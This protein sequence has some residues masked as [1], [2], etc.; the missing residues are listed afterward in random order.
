VRE[1]NDW[2]EVTGCD[3]PGVG[4]LANPAKRAVRTGLYATV[5]ECQATVIRAM[6]V[7]NIPSLLSRVA[8]RFTTGGKTRAGVCRYS[9][10]MRSCEIML[11][12]T[13]WGA[14]TEEQRFNVLMHEAA[15]AV[16]FL[17]HG[18]SSHDARWQAIA[19]QLGCTGDRCLS[20]EETDV[21]RGA[22]AE[23]KGLPAP[24]PIAD[25][26]A[27]SEAAKASLKV[28]DNVSFEHKGQRLYGRLTARNDKSATVFMAPGAMGERGGSAR[29]PWH[30]LQK[31]APSVHKEK[32]EGVDKP[33]A[34]ESLS[35]WQE[36]TGRL[37]ANPAARKKWLGGTTAAF[38]R[39][40][41]DSVVV[42]EDGQPKACYHGTK[43]GGFQAFSKGKIDKHHAGFFFSDNADV[44][45][46][47]TSSSN[48]P[49]YGKQ[50]LPFQ[51]PKTI[52]E[53]E[54][55]LRQHVIEKRFFSSA[56][57]QK[58][59]L[60]LAKSQSFSTV[61]Y[62]AGEERSFPW[63]FV[64]YWGSAPGDF[65]AVVYDGGSS[66]E[67]LQAA[68]DAIFSS[69]VFVDGVASG[70]DVGI[71]RVYLRIE[72]PFVV[73]AKGNQ[74]NRIPV[75]SS[76]GLSATTYAKEVQAIYKEIRGVFKP[77]SKETGYLLASV[78]YAQTVLGEPETKTVKE[79]LAFID[80]LV[81]AFLR[82]KKTAQIELLLNF[83]PLSH[84]YDDDVNE[85]L[86]KRFPVYAAVNT[87]M[88]AKYTKGKIVD[89]Q[90]MR[91]STDKLAHQAKDAGYDG[92]IIK[93]V[94][95]SG[96]GGD[97]DPA[98][99]VYVVFDPNQVKSAHNDGTWSREDDN[100]LRNPPDDAVSVRFDG[101][102]RSELDIQAEVEDEI[103]DDD[104]YA[105]VL[106]YYADGVLTCP[107]SAQ[108][109]VADA[110]NELSNAY[111]EQ[112]RVGGGGESRAVLNAISQGFGTASSRLRRQE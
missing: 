82:E 42:T 87:F 76:A 80:N 98:G 22:W 51:P 50:P 109:D 57:H 39:W 59:K 73:D 26:I 78:A 55:V 99:T 79:A 100:L 3:G 106:P 33:A 31:E 61:E 2:I 95:D 81:E 75:P 60:Y 111:E 28:G 70:V 64:L 47:Y 85:D 107:R 84:V 48:D 30:L 68:R 101:Y 1:P 8:V 67:C 32:V 19:K 7:F 112:A 96:G 16:D 102:A 88:E 18:R 97:T 89:T 52:V 83:S 38:R 11:N 90:T 72:N 74:W 15:H 43:S 65:H 6:S 25:L 24:R 9:L 4:L 40:F 27:E 14:F 23:K 58:G 77:S 10:S 46:T 105:V 54:K 34:G 86:K 103:G 92:L 41:G 20:V 13:V 69:Q 45:M 17:R 71:Y 36:R 91:T 44:S 66:A 110:L 29:V 56:G 21:M 53:L 12:G 37:R 104:L 49:L 35:S 5:E 63:S 62:E 93:N 108:Q 94:H